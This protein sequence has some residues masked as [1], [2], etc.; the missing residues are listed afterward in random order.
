MFLVVQL[1]LALTVPLKR[2]AH[3]GPVAAS[4]HAP[5]VA[6]ADS[7]SDSAAQGNR[8][9]SVRS[10]P[11]RRTKRCLPRRTTES[12]LLYLGKTLCARGWVA[13]SEIMG[14]VLGKLDEAT[15][16]LFQTAWLGR[17]ASLEPWHSA[18]ALTGSMR[19]S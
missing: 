7:S 2:N 1:N 12:K 6:A 16:G 13:S 9:R 19:G 17:L 10:K 5:E 3:P 15:M 18:G 11:W 14:C 8:R 4:A